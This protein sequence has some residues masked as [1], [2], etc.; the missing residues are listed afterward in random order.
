MH[1]R[2]FVDASFPVYTVCTVWRRCWLRCL[3]THFSTGDGIGVPH[4][5]ARSQE[6]VLFVEGY[7]AAEDRMWQ[8]DT[9]RRLAAGELCEVLG[10]VAIESE[11]IP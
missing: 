9:L 5:R 2:P 1:P 3:Q 4:I 10:P 6:D 11:N 8:M 7:A